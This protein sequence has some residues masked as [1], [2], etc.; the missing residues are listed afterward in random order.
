MCP[1]DTTVLVVSSYAILQPF[2]R[3]VVFWLKGKYVCQRA[4]INMQLARQVICKLA[5]I[6]ILKNVEDKNTT[7]ALSE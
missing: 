7:W 1:K 2:H 4:T 5:L 6:W 3:K